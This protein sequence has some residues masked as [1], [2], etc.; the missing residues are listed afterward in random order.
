M[1]ASTVTV[2]VLLFSVLRERVGT[3]QVEVTVPAP[4]S[5]Q[6]VVTAVIAAHPSIAPY[7]SIV[8]VAVNHEYVPDAASV[9]GGD[10]VALI[11]PVSGG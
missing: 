6:D 8:R 5:A 9:T 11:T 2:S 1:S 3:G 7:E 4:A 10:E